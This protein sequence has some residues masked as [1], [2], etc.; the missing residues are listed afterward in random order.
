MR[1]IKL[2][3]SETDIKK[4][5]LEDEQEVRL[6]DLIEKINLEYAK[7]A[8]K[9]CN[10]IASKAGLSEMSIDEINEEIKAVRDAKSNY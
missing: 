7:N 1:T 5:D 6:A 9:Q 10:D 4:Y 3:V 2:K 8:L